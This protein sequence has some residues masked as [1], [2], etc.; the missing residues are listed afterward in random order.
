MADSLDS[1]RHYRIVGGNDDDGKVGH[2][3]A[4][5]THSREGLMSRGVEECN[6]AAA[7]ELHVVGSDV[8]GDSSGLAGNHVSLS[9]VVEQGCFSVVDVSHD[10][11]H[12]RPRHKILRL[13]SL[14]LGIDFLRKVGG[15]ELD[16]I[17]ELFSDEHEG[18]R[19]KALI[20]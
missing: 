19:I 9:D 20:D 4:S 2:L 10:R 11:N 15:H 5:G 12:R 13:V 6:P 17:A 18:L 3:S 7:R 14:L 16:L 1:L 8:L